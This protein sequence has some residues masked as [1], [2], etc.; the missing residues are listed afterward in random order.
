MGW[1]D[2]GCSPSLIFYP[3][4]KIKGGGNRGDYVNFC[5]GYTVSENYVYL[6]RCCY[7]LYQLQQWPTERVSTKAFQTILEN[8][9]ADIILSQILWKFFFLT[10][11][12]IRMCP[13]LLLVSKNMRMRSYIDMYYIFWLSTVAV[14]NPFAQKCNVQ[15]TFAKNIGKYCIVTTLYSS[16]SQCVLFLSIIK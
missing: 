14:A 6:Y 3:C 16:L 1:K 5:F 7:W 15:F 10:S 8:L 2:F 13:P 9:S 11:I 4:W 12:Y